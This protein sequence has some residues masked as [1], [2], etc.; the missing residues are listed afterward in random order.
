M[1]QSRTEFLPVKALEQIMALKTPEQ[2][3]HGVKVV[4]RAFM[5]I[6]SL[7]LNLVFSTRS[8]ILPL[9]STY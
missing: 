5:P 3:E 1:K 2:L 7:N 6:C 9:R 4:L 8:E